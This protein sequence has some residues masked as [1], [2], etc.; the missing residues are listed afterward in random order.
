MQGVEN[1]NWGLSS[2]QEEREG[3][4]GTQQGN[5]QKIRQRQEQKGKARGASLRHC[6]LH[7]FQN[8]SFLLN[9]TGTYCTFTRQATALC[10]ILERW[11]WIEGLLVFAIMRRT[12]TLRQDNPSEATWE[13]SADRGP[14]ILEPR[15]TS[16]PGLPASKF[17]PV[18][19]QLRHIAKLKGMKIN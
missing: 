15:T 7:K 10:S 12:W 8:L 4:Q 11:R 1:R 5:R 9:V 6:P 3:R 18:L 17:R 16:R 2:K 14:W 13:W 19:T